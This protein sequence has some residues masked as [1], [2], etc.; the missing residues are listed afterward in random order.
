M[1]GRT[2]V[3][4]GL[5]LAG[6]VP[7]Q[8]AGRC[9][10]PTWASAQ[11]V[12]EERNALPAADLTDATLRQIVRVSVGG[13]A[14]RVRISNLHGTAPLLIGAA[15][16]ALSADPASPRLQ[17]GGMVLRFAG[18]STITIPAG[19]EYLSDPVDLAVPSLAHLAVSLF[20]PQAPAQQTSHP[21]SRATSYLARGNAAGAADLPGAKSVTHWYQLAAV[22]V[23]ARPGSS[24]I[25]TLGDSIT[26]GY[27]VQPDTDLRW[28]DHL[29]R[30]LQQ[31]HGRVAVLNHGIGGN[32]LLADGLGPNAMA[33]FERAIAQPGVSHVVVLEGVNDLGTLGRDGGDA[34][35]YRDLADRMIVAYSQIVATARARGVRAIGATIMPYGGSDYYRSTAASEAARQAVNDWIRRHFDAVIDFDKVMRDPADPLRLRPDLD[36]GD[37]LHPS[38]AGYKAMA[39]AVP[40]DLFG[41]AGSQPSC[42]QTAE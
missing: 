28:P 38:L 8:A 23:D 34:A 31:K 32:R 18:R 42:R 10:L 11:Q 6:A 13:E 1:A 3:L 17:P 36:S 15:H 35:A 12:P 39:E 20:L 25:V 7:A 24:A 33:R 21:G 41:K 9:W 16:V 4:L 5:L 27:G 29:A 26:D 37:H 22:E 19:A 2:P 40:L 14:V 30:R